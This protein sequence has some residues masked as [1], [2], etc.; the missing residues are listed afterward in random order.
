MERGSGAAKPLPDDGLTIVMR[1]AD[2]ED[3]VRLEGVGDL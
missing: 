2:E 3:T 1:G